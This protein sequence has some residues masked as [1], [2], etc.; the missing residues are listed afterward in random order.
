MHAVLGDRKHLRIAY[1]QQVRLHPQADELLLG[2]AEIL[3]TSNDFL[4]G[5]ATLGER[6]SRSEHAGFVRQVG[7]AEIDA[8]QRRSRFNA[9]SVGCE[10]TRGA[11]AESHKRAPHARHARHWNAQRETNRTKLIKPPDFRACIA[12]RR[13]PRSEPCSIQSKR[14]QRRLGLWSMQRDARVRCQPRLDRDLFRKQRLFQRSLHRGRVVHQRVDQQDVGKLYDHQIRFDAPLAIDEERARNAAIDKLR[15]VL[16]HQTIYKV[17]AIL[18]AQRERGAV[19]TIDKRGAAANCGVLE[20]DLGERC[21]H[22]TSRI[23]RC[24]GRTE[25]QVLDFQSRA[26]GHGSARFTGALATARRILCS[27]RAVLKAKV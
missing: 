23:T 20:L 10:P 9:R 13:A 26:R 27:K 4:P 21:N 1:W 12:K 8:K 2:L 19:R 16:R 18:A 24:I 5:I 6:N 11:S 14:L 3:H 22:L 17:N 15:D 7:R 25:G